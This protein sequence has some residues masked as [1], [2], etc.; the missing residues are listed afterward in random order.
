M[1]QLHTLV[2]ALPQKEGET[3][4]RPVSAAEESRAAG[5]GDPEPMADLPR[6]IWTKPLTQKEWETACAMITWWAMHGGC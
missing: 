1:D 5:P 4:G 6:H 2:C 3:T